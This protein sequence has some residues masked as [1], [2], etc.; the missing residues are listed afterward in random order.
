MLLLCRFGG[1]HVPSPHG[2]QVPG[3]TPGWH[4]GRR[5]CTPT[6]TMPYFLA[7]EEWERQ[8]EGGKPQHP[9]QHHCRIW[10]P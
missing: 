8:W 5:D 3:L 10:H 2:P 7:K 6:G 9:P 4:R 1:C